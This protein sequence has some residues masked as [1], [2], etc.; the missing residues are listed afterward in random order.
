MINKKEFRSFVL[1]QLNNDAAHA[2]E[3][4]LRSQQFEVDYSYGDALFDCAAELEK[5][6]ITFN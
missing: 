5:L 4:Y 1:A 2:A 6:N 3:M